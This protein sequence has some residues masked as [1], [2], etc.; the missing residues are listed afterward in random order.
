VV[1]LDAS[2][3]VVEAQKARASARQPRWELLHG[4]AFE[5]PNIFGEGEVTTVVFCSVLHEIFSYVAWGDPPKRFQLGSVEAIVRAAFRTLKKGG[6]IIVRDGLAP[7]DEPRVIELKDPRWLEGLRLFARSFE[8]RNP[9]PLEELPDGRIRLGQRDLYEFL[10]TFTW[11]PASFP[12]EIREQ[13]A[14]LPR[15][16]YVALLLRACEAPGATAKEVAVPPELASYLQPG[17]SQH[18]DPYVA[19]FDA[20]GEKR[21]KLPDVQGVIVIERA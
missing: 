14:V 1:G 13:R 15:D 10:T 2:A 18:I 19:V 21:V 5:L 3:A 7:A 9:I 20:A 12:Y 17:Y 4:D 6:R 11:G 16:E 8:A